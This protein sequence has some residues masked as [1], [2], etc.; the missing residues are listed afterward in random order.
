[1]EQ[2]QELIIRVHVLLSVLAIFLSMIVGEVSLAGTDVERFQRQGDIEARLVLETAPLVS[3]GGDHHDIR[4]SG[5]ALT[6]EITGP[7]NLEVTPSEPLVQTKNW[8]SA[9]VSRRSNA[10][11]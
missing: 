6:L 3:D 11:P 1:M 8:Q 4:L 10:A 5:E 2:V 7:A 9:R